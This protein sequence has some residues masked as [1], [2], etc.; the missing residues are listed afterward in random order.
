MIGKIHPQGAGGQ[1]F[2]LIAIDYFTKWVE[3]KSYRTLGAKEVA[4]FIQTNIICRYGI[5]HE[6]ISDQG[7]HFR[8]ETAAILEKYH[9]KHHKS[10][11]YRPQTN[12]AVEAA[13]KTLVTIIEKMAENHRDWPNK[14]PFAL[15]GYHTT[16]RTPTGMTPYFLTYGMEAVQPV[17]IEIPSLRILIESQIPKA[18][19]CRER[20]EQLILLDERRLNSLSTVQ[21]YHSRLQR[22][23]NKKVRP[24]NIKVGDLVLKSV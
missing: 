11:P 8:G 7:T 23:F 22:A 24:R 12:R 6:F 21:M 13:N 5:P 10:S 14:I 15:W 2:V 16:I 1:C 19:W 17:E 18:A 4:K 20:Y 3:A 9:I